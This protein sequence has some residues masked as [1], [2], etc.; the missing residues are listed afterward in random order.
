MILRRVIYI[1][2]FFQ[3]DESNQLH[4]QRF[5]LTFLFF[6]L[7]DSANNMRNRM[8]T[9]AAH[10]KSVPFFMH[11]V[12]VFTLGLKIFQRFPCRCNGFILFHLNNHSPRNKAYI[13][14]E[15]MIIYF[16]HSNMRRYTGYNWTKGQVRS[17]VGHVWSCW[18]GPYS[19]WIPGRQVTTRFRFCLSAP[20]V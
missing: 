18:K 11:G 13:N 12:G 7:L 1:I 19:A 9:C 14:L 6:V 20:L 5:C 3:K 4:F 10:T 15:W 17:L 2:E 8:L 16:T